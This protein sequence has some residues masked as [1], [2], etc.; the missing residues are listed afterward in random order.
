MKLNTIQ[1]SIEFII[2]LKW[3][4]EDLKKAQKMLLDWDNRTESYYK[5]I[6]KLVMKVDMAE[7]EHLRNSINYWENQLNETK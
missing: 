5:N 2:D 6:S 7:R 4:D 1:T 3:N